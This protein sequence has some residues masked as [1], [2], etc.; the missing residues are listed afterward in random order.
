[1][2]ARAKPANAGKLLTR[3]SLGFIVDDG[4]R[5]SI[6]DRERDRQHAWAEAVVEQPEVGDTGSLEQFSRP[7]RKVL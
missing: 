2:W 4:P 3:T 7:A 5:C 1:L 6:Q